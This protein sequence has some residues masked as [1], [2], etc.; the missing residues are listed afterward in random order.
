MEGPE[1]HISVCCFCL[2][3]VSDHRY[4]NQ[5]RSL[6]YKSTLNLGIVTQGERSHVPKRQDLGNLQCDK[7]MY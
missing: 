7:V 3:H 6:L 1:D 5:T 2:T 4:K